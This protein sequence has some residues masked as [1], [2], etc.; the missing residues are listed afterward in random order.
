MWMDKVTTALAEAHFARCDLK[1]RREEEEGY[2]LLS[3]Y[4]YE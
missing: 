2:E 4:G 3:K 1:V